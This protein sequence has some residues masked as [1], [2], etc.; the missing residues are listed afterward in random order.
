MLIFT[1]NIVFS[2]AYRD[3]RNSPYTIIQD[4]VRTDEIITDAC[5]GDNSDIDSDDELVENE[6]V[7]DEDS[8]VMNLPN[9]YLSAPGRGF[10]QHAYSCFDM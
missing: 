4:R 7:S 3:D 9:M 6:E 10:H 8:F 1:K 5:G 2:E